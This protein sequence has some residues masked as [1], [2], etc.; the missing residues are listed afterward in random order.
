MVILDGAKAPI[1]DLAGTASRRV[2]GR[3]LVSP[4]VVRRGPGFR[5]DDTLC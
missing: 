3:W 2:G 4:H 5:Q 1:Q